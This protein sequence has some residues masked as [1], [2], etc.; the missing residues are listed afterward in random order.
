MTL[1]RLTPAV[2][3]VIGI[4]LHFYTPAIAAP[5]DGGPVTQGSSNV[6]Q[7]LALL[8][9]ARAQYVPGYD[10]DLF[11]PEW[12]DVDGNSCDTR[13]DILLRDLSRTKVST[14]DACTV[15]SG[16]LKDPYTGK[17]IAFLRGPQT[18]WAVHVDHVVSLSD[19][20]SNGAYLW[21]SNLR[22]RFANDPLNLL[23]VD[24]PTNMRKGDSN[25]AEWLPPRPASRCSYVA[26]QV[27]V[28]AKYGLSVTAAE[29]SAMVRV[30]K[31]CPNEKLPVR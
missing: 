1:R 28:K 14:S 17:N 3:A 13:N 31:K 18:S 23:A 9:N 10:R 19:A 26:R 11:G 25:A 16:S 5:V 7:S 12:Y 22:L 6:V 21:Q 20:W 2:A 24:G 15:L 27:A 8:P 4:T 30:L 29:R